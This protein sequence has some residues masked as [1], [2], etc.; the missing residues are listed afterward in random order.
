MKY[1][2]GVPGIL[3]WLTHIL[4]GL[5]FVYLGY[6]MNKTNTFK[7]HGIV[8]IVLGFTMAAYH[9]HLMFLKMDII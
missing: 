7:I 1:S 5:Y 2:F 3:I 8:L 4:T 6:S 9:S